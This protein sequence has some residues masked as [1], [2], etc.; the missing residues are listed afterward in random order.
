MHSLKME[1]KKSPEKQFG[2]RT[3]VFKTF[4]IEKGR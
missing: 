3:N 1:E 4:N 2:G